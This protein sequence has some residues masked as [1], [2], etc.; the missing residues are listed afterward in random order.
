[1]AQKNVTREQ[2]DE[3]DAQGGLWQ[4]DAEIL[5]PLWVCHP[6]YTSTCSS[7]W[8]LSKTLSLV[9]P[10]PHFILNGGFIT[11]TNNMID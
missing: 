8:K 10:P 6:P 7:I 3:R 4:K 5:C 9:L 2:P 11:L 1:M